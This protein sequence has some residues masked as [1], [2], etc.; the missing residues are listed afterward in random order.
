MATATAIRHNRDHGGTESAAE[1]LTPPTCDAGLSSPEV[2]VLIKMEQLNRSNEEDTR[3]VASRKSGSSGSPKTHEPSPAEDDEEDLWSIWGDVIRNWELEVKKNPNTIKMLVKRGIPQ[4][5]RTIAWQ[6]LSNA[7]VSS[8]HEAYSDYMRQSSAYEKVVHRDISRTYPE[9]EFFKDGGRGQASLFNVIKAYS[10][11]DKEVGYCQGSAFIVGLLLMQMPEEEAFAVLVRLMENYRLRELY[12]PTMT[13]LGLCMFQLECLVQEQ[14]PDLHT[15]FNNMGFDTSMY[16]SSWFLTLFTTTLP[17]EI[18]NRIMDC[19]LVEGMEFIFRIAMSILQQ[20][21]IDLLRLDMEGML[22]YFQRDIRERYENDADLL[23]VVANKVQLNPR[24][25]RR[26]EKD[27]LAKRTKEQEEAIELRRL[28]TENRLL[29]QRIDYLEAES[30]A[31]ADRLVKGQVNLAQEAENSINIAHELNKLRDINSDAHRKLEQAY[32]TIRE[33]SCSRHGEM[34]DA[35]V[36]VDDTSMIEHIHSLQQELIES[37]NRQADHENT[38]RE[39]KIRISELEAANKRLREHE[40]F[41]G[42]AGLQEELISVK[43]REAESNL[44]VKEMR[45]RLS[46]LEQHWARYV[47]MRAFDPS[48]ASIESETASNDSINTPSLNSARAKLAKITAS[49]IGGVP[50]GDDGCITVRELEDQLMGVRIKEAD[51]LAE[52][53]EMRQKVMELETQNHVC[54]N[55]LRRQDDEMKRV[56]EEIEAVQKMRRELEMSLRQERQRCVQRESEL[57]EQCI[58]E[59]LKYSEAMQSVQELRQTITQLELKKAEG[60]TQNQLRGSS[61]CEVDDDCTSHLSMGSNGDV[62]SLGSEDLNALVADM[63]VKVPI[64]DE[65]GSNTET[66][67]HRPKEAQD[68][69]ATGDSGVHNS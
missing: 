23:F 61:V 1:A 21:R 11:H 49:I 32:D 12:K 3:S 66:E 4:H 20:A 67:D 8:V 60:W 2:D 14:M 6:L 25:M 56:R 47:H 33:L 15:H 31:L 68:G 53:K 37:H 50:D 54:T 59:R 48:S 30:A 58:M 44:A 62:F 41:E 29:R 24:K 40:P 9:L 26:L 13:D 46:E 28:R 51:N 17:I 35:G 42:V 63:T 34:I 57:N 52:L 19:F 39:C 7:S 38:I 36:Q 22:K 45:Q 10:V 69:N 55:Q 18:A 43:M 27:Y 64:L 65:E 5:F 16:A